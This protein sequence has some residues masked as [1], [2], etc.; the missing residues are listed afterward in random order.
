MNGILIID[1]P[2]DF[3]S[4]DVIAIVRGCMHERK[5][6]HTGTLDPMATGVLPILLGSATKAQELLPDTDKEYIAEFRLGMTTDTLDITGK[7]LSTSDAEVTREQLEEV[8]PKFRGDIM[9]KPPMYSAVYK[10]GVRLY[11]LARKG[12]EVE[13]EERPANVSLLELTHFDEAAQSGSLKISCSKGTYIRVICNDI[14]RLLGCGCVMTSLRRTRACG[15]TL[16][17]A[18]TLAKLRELAPLGQAEA[19]VK[20]VDSIF[21]HLRSVRISEKQTVRFRNGASLMLSRLSSIKNAEDGELFRVYG[22]D[23]VFLGLGMAELEKQSLTV[24]KRFD[25]FN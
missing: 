7:T 3:T 4:F 17:D 20:P 24:R 9:Q 15:Y 2:Q 21:A 11:E 6:G 14:G 23:G 5:T 13:R 25:Q 16:D 12:I 8:L 10:D 18:V 19:L 1:K 22:N